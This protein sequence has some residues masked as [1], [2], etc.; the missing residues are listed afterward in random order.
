[1]RA[2][3][4]RLSRRSLFAVPALALAASQLAVAPAQ[5]AP[6][7]AVRDRPR[8]TGLSIRGADL[9]FTPQLEAAGVTFSDC[10]STQPVER[11]LAR[12]GANYV[13]LRV[14]IDPPAGYSDEAS[15]LRMARRAKQAGMKVL[16][17]LHYSDFWADP[18]HQTTPASWQGQ[19]L[20]TLSETVYGYTRRLI[21]T[22]ARRGAPVDLVQ[23][24]NEV[25]AGMLWPVGQIY[26]ADG[27][28]W[29]EFTTLL[30]AGIAGARAGDPGHHQLDVMIHVDRGGDSGG[31][32]WFYDHIA[33]QGVVDYDVIGLS[34]Y[35]FWHGPLAD[36]SANL[37]DAAARYGKPLVIAEAAYP[38]TLDNGD[39]LGNFITSP[40]QLPD[41]AL[42]PATP[43]GQAAYF[44]AVR[45]ILRQVPDGLGAGFFDWSPEW[46][47]GV[48]W[49]P[50]EGN[51]NDNLTMFDWQGTAL[52]SVA[53]F[54]AAH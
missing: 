21:E 43:Q 18:A 46:I 3:Q 7:A 14:W 31:T 33:E 27:A 24:G 2:Q 5:A 1:M 37:N 16:L 23:I 41:G 20:A 40:D 19:D 8:R 6:G 10:G 44:E 50:G 49:A 9:S 4:T 42:Y 25:T 17:D 34:Y 32:R 54:R 51:P 38:W 12:H 53:A 47:P 39:Q 35:P 36:L 30:K 26:Q 15:A 13:R 45:A 28:H 22:F 48:G 29:P 11:I 52:P